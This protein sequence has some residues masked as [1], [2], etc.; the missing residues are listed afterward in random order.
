[1]LV[2]VLLDVLLSVLTHRVLGSGCSKGRIFALYS[3]FFTEV[4]GG[5]PPSVVFGLNRFL[6]GGAGVPGAAARRAGG[7]GAFRLAALCA[8][9]RCRCRHAPEIGHRDFLGAIKKSFFTLRA[10]RL[11]PYIY[12]AMKPNPMIKRLLTPQVIERARQLALEEIPRHCLERDKAGNPLPNVCNVSQ[13]ILESSVG[14]DAGMIFLNRFYHEV[15]NAT[16]EHYPEESYFNF[17][18]MINAAGDA[19]TFG[20]F[21]I[22]GVKGYKAKATPEEIESARWLISS[23]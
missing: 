20:K 10:V 6:A 2:Y 22:P 14:G 11:A 15:E 3:R 8:L 1:V 18:E 23:F 16:C 21:S 4:R 12:S 17:F 19:V 13:A 7:A 5:N 9:R